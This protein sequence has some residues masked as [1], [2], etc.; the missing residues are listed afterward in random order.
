VEQIKVIRLDTPAE[1]KERYGPFNYL[2]NREG[3]KTACLISERGD[4]LELNAVWSE[5]RISF[6]TLNFCT[7]TLLLEER[8]A[9]CS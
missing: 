2:A 6:P 3:L 9:F 1:L 8:L 7:L 5:E 4:T